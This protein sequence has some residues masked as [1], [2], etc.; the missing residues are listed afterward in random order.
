MV[1]RS[2]Q[3]FDTTED[4]KAAKNANGQ[5]VIKLH[6]LATGKW[7]RTFKGHTSTIHAIAFSSDSK[8][9]ASVSMDGTVRLWNVFHG[10]QV[11]MPKMTTASHGYSLTYSPDGKQLAKTVGPT[12]GQAVVSHSGRNYHVWFSLQSRR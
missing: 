11:Q 1:N 2:K 8:T 4:V 7:V 12:K 6:D 10:T 9:L 3:K 5:Y